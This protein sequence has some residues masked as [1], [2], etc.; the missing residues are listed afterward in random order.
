MVSLIRTLARTGAAALLVGTAGCGIDNLLDQEAPGRVGAETLEDPSNAVL[1]VQSAIGSFQC[2]LASYA[3]AS[4][5]VADELDDAHLG[6]PGWDLDRRTMQPQTGAWATSD[7]DQTLSTQLPGVYIPLSQARFQA[8]EAVRLLTG[9]TDAQVP[10]RGRLLA[11]ALTYSAFSFLL[12]G[13]AMCSAAFDLGPEMTSQQILARAEERFGEALAAATA[14]GETDMASASLVGRARARLDL[15]HGA[16]ARADAEQVPPG[17]ALLAVY[18][19]PGAPVRRENRVATQLWRDN[20]ATV[21][22][23]YRG[24]Q[25]QGIADP[26]VAVVDR[27]VK[28]ADGASEIWAT[29]KYQT[30]NSPITVASGREAQLIIAEVAGGQTAVDIINALHS[31][32]G[33]PPFS[34][35]DPAAIRAQVI[36]E[37]RREFFLDGHRLADLRRFSIPLDPPAGAPSRRGGTYGS[38]LCFPLPD[39]E[40][41]NNPNL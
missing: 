14:A 18:D 15:G 10:D 39:V 34:S 40:R 13:E 11:R 6:A 1:L 7:C 20:Y 23:A 3:T 37:R 26:R 19:G 8:D 30:Q 36:E 21:S 32:A 31:A 16:D 35:S 2:A 41:L 4:G 17:F 29:T 25:F 24:L 33:I 38:Q 12:M 28:G 22:A 27:G 5:T 9:W